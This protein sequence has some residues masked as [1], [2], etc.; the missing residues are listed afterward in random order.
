M[1]TPQEIKEGID[2]IEEIA[3][4]YGIEDVY[5]VGGYPRSIAMGLSVNDVHDLDVA[6]GRPGRAQE[7]AGFVAEAGHAD[8]FHEHHRTTAITVTFGD[9]EIDFQGAETHEHVLPYVRLYGV[10]ETPISMNIFDRDF[11]INALA[12]KVGTNKIEDI[13]KRGLLD[14]ERKM[15]VSILPPEI[16][17]KNDPLMIT[18]AIKLSAKYGFDID[19]SLWKEMR[20]NSGALEKKISP[21]RLAIEAYILSR[22]PKAKEL[23]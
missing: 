1:P 19:K 17:V 12:I 9:L 4:K 14:I 21:E 2:L 22:Y 11:T 3:F 13:T 6:S 10:P 18:R 20:R 15:V 8:D 16:R 5:F 23:I 7:L